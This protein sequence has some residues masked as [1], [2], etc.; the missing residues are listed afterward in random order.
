MFEVVVRFCFPLSFLLLLAAC[1]APEPRT[2]GPRIDSGTARKMTSVMKAVDSLPAEED[3]FGIEA[4]ANITDPAEKS[5]LSVP[6]TLWLGD[7]LTIRF[8]VPHP[9]DLAIYDP[10]NNFFFLVYD[11]LLNELKPLV[12]HGRFARMD[13]LDLPASLRANA[14]LH[15]VDTL[16]P[17]F[18][19]PGNYRIVLSKELETDEG[20]PIEEERV[21]YT[22]RRRRQ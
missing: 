10:E 19:K 18:T 16:Q 20:T 1:G 6:D 22:A 8:R 13:R 21:Y 11:H 17:V 5:I 7:T 3:E 2:P 14:W 4:P 12:P 9:T 15:G